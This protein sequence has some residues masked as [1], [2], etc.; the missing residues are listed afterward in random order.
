MLL[1]TQR[2]VFVDLHGPLTTLRPQ[3]LVILLRLVSDRGPSQDLVILQYL[4]CHQSAEFL[5]SKIKSYHQSSVIIIINFVPKKIFNQWIHYYLFCFLFD[6]KQRTSI[7]VLTKVW[8]LA[9]RQLFHFYYNI[10]ICPCAE[11]L[12]LNIIIEGERLMVGK[13]PKLPPE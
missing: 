8:D 5:V 3:Q 9:L 4:Y 13:N 12:F 11:Y 2:H 1:E 7:G 6:R 10:W